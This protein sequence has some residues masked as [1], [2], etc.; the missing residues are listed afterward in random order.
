MH[1]CV[2]EV[3]FFFLGSG[4]AEGVISPVSSSVSHSDTNSENG[5]GIGKES[6]GYSEWKRGGTSKLRSASSAAGGADEAR[7]PDW[8][9]DDEP[10][11]PI[12]PIREREK[13]RR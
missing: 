7:S 6:M 10:I 11:A 13:G 2:C 12:V 9:V 1:F 8:E 4:P 3:V 5:H